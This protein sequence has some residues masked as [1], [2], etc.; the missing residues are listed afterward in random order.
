MNEK[1]CSINPFLPFKVADIRDYR[2]AEVEDSAAAVYRH[3][4]PV[5]VEQCLE[6]LLWVKAL[7]EGDNFG[8]WFG[9]EF[10]NQRGY[11]RRLDERLVALNVDNDVGLDAETSVSL[12]HARG[13]VGAVGGGHD[14]FPSEALHLS[15]YAAVVSSNIYIVNHRTGTLVDMADHTFTPMSTR[16]FPGSG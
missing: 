11:Y 13:T 10:I 4:H 15:D 6:S 1:F 7:R 16:G 8:I 3:F 12:G 2:T 5:W 14:G 9:A